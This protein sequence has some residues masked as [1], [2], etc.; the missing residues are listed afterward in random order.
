[1]LE[2]NHG[3]SQKLAALS[4]HFTAHSSGGKIAFKGTLEGWAAQQADKAV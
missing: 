2:P 3:F 1:M 4:G